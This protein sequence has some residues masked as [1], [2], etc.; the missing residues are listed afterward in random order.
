MMADADMQ[1]IITG[2]P[3]CKNERGRS[4]NG[5]VL[6]ICGTAVDSLPPC[7]MTQTKG[8]HVASSA[9][10]VRNLES[11]VSPSIRFLGVGVLLII[12]CVKP[13]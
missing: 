10:V 3:G 13:G 7:S 12:F 1:S 6:D 2:C 4:C 9:V 8:I 11:A 5:C